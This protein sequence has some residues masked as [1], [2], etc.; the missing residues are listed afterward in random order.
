MKNEFQAFFNAQFRQKLRC[1]LILH[2]KKNINIVKNHAQYSSTT[3]YRSY[4]L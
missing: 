3:R 2:E 4:G 1:I